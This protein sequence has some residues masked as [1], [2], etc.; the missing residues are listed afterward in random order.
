MEEFSIIPE[1][2]ESW[3]TSARSLARLRFERTGERTSPY[4]SLP[5]RE[6]YKAFE[7]AWTVDGRTVIRS[8]EVSRWGGEYSFDEWSPWTVEE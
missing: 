5:E 1:T 4:L 3:N 6:T 7:R 2:I 8:R